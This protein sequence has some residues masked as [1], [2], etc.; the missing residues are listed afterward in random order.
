MLSD[1]RKFINTQCAYKRTVHNAT[2]SNPQPLDREVSVLPLDYHRSPASLSRKQHYYS[3]K[4]PSH[5][6]Q[7]ESAPPS[8]ILLQAAPSQRCITHHHRASVLSMTQYIAS[9]PTRLHHLAWL[10]HFTALYTVTHHPASYRTISHHI[11]PFRAISHRSAPYRIIPHHIALICTTIT[12][13][14]R[15]PPPATNQKHT[16]TTK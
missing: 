2:Y 7:R 3:H 13:P 16:V 12:I 6:T 4:V 9:L 14:Y 11:T 10:N 8:T 1:P 5:T 15:S